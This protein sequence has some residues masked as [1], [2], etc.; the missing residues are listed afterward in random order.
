M[1][2][3]RKTRSA[4]NDP[5][6]QVQRPAASAQVVR[7]FLGWD[8][9]LVRAVVEHLAASWSGDGALDLSHWLVIVPTRNASRRLREAL[10][11]HAAERGAAVLPPRVVTPDFL[12]S[13]EHVP[14]LNPAGALESRLLWAAELLRLNL[15]EFRALFPIDPVERDFTWALQTADDLLD[16]RETLNEKGLSCED[17]ARIVENTEMEPERWRDLAA[18]ERRC[19]QAT[20]ARG[21]ADWQATRRQA[22]AN[23]RPPAGVTRVVVAGVLD[24]SGLA[25]AALETWSRE[26]PVEVLIYAPKNSHHDLFDS[27]GRP[28]SAAW[29]THGIDIPDAT[30]TIHPCATPTEQAVKAAELIACYDEPEEMVAFGVADRAV[31]APLEKALAER[32]IGSF[33]PAGRKMSTHGVL[34]LLRIMARLASVRTFRSV[35]ELVR[36]PDVA[37]AIRA[38]VERDT[39][40][41]PALSRL[42]DD[43]DTLAAEALPDTLDDAMELAPRVFSDPAHPSAVPHALQWVQRVLQA[44]AGD[45][46]AAALTDF[47]GEVFATRRFHS[48]NPQDAV[49]AAIADQMMQSLESLEELAA[50][51]PS[52]FDAARRLELLLHVLEGQSFHPERRAR[53]I[54]LQGWLELLWEDAPHLIITG[55]NDGSAPEAIL[56]HVFL[57]DSARRM[58][59]LRDNDSRFAR[60]AC[61][62]TALISS[63]QGKG[64]RV[65]FIFGRSAEDGTPL[66]P[67]RLLFQCTDAELP[68]RTL[69]FFQKTATRTDSAPWQL[70][71]RLRPQPL[72]ESASILHRLSVTQFAAYLRCPF[73]FYL[74][75]GLG[76]AATG[77]VSTEMD[78]MEFGSL[79]HGVLENFAKDEEA[80]ALS[81]AAKIRSVFH[82]LLDRRLHHT[83]GSRL[84]VPVAIQRESA[85]QRLGWWAEVEAEQRRQGWQIIE[86]ETRLSPK[87]DP[88]QL[89]GMTISG[90]IDRIEQHAQFGVRL[91]DF[92]TRSA[93]DSVKKTRKTVENHHLTRLKR[94]EERSEFPEWSLATDSEGIDVRWSDL[95][96]PLYRL[97]MERRYPGEK[98]TTAHVTL[99]KT[100][101]EVGLD[102]WQTLEGCLL[103]SARACAEGVIAAIR[104][105]Q[106]WPPAT[107]LPYGDDFEALFFGEPMEAVDASL[108]TGKEAA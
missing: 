70:A 93:F 2:M 44:L 12:T 107:E 101:P 95:Q 72:P 97:A 69:H 75:H 99:S 90:R 36:C 79:L 68:A 21:F 32:G 64:G 89:A 108:L 78:A 91:I 88:W 53:D 20:E 8:R 61:L 106:F 57:P 9:P 30:A 29:L 5:P 28:Q 4:S 31:V 7:H 3:P 65:D 42:L 55:M 6:A 24:P 102:E 25:I 92:K 33:D 100:K 96:L 11:A 85:R 34:Y 77:A 51:F 84:T 10:A 48:T 35:A 46:F 98:I 39:G 14:E 94:G 38:A 47:L 60:D 104:A 17:V 58:L 87:D 26:V 19:V 41:K 86:A 71:W 37:E 66:R 105:Q 67:S 15:D 62:M 1:R 45:D 50:L 63:R 22:A 80:R 52:G 13:P 74:G 103:E 56:G 81:D 59:G 40:E 18:V 83:Y 27:W 16:L 76:M 23:G 54:D 82:H 43:F 49:F 73:R